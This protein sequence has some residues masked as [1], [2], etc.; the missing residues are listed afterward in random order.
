MCCEIT[1]SIVFDK[2]TMTNFCYVALS[3]YVCMHVWYLESGNLA[4]AIIVI[5]ELKECCNGLALN[6][7]R[8]IE[9]Y[10]NI[11]NFDCTVY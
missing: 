1:L 11:I 7:D 2:K 3:M 8:L 9:I 10:Q 5:F 6:K 4:G